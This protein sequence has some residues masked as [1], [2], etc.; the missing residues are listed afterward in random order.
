[1]KRCF[2]HIQCVSI[3][4]SRDWIGTEWDQHGMISTGSMSITDQHGMISTGS[5]RDDQHG[6]DVYHAR[7]N[8]TDTDCV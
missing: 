1:M 5:A 6:I 8:A 3:I 7:C 4:P 2:N